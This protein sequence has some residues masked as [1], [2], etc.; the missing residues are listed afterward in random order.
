VVV[1]TGSGL[2]KLG[3]VF[4]DDLV[5]GPVHFLAGCR[6]VVDGFAAAAEL[7]TDAIAHGADSLTLRGCHGSDEYCRV[8]KQARDCMNLNAGRE[9]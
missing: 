1:R 2:E 9:D 8:G 4:A 7:R 6:A 3:V 5:N